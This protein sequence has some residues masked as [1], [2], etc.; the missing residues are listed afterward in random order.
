MA[1]WFKQS[2]CRLLLYILR[3]LQPLRPLGLSSLFAAFYYIECCDFKLLMRNT[4][5]DPKSVVV[6]SLYI[7]VKSIMIWKYFQCGNCLIEY[8]DTKE[9][10]MIVNT[11]NT[12]FVRMSIALT[13]TELVVR[14][15]NYSTIMPVNFTLRNLKIDTENLWFCFTAEIPVSILTQFELTMFTF[16]KSASRSI[17]RTTSSP[18]RNFPSIAH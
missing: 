13:T 12:I 18:N 16:R 3:T 5:S 1:K 7:F 17:P 6:V 11:Y 2:T 4:S 9:M 14:I 8:P 10:N 15:A